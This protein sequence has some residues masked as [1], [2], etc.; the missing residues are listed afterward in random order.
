MAQLSDDCFAF[1][2]ELMTT[3]EALDLLAERLE[4]VVEPEPVALRRALGRILAADVVADRS[5]PPLDNAAVDGY[6]VCFGD[7][8]SGGETRLPVTGR[9]AAGQALDRTP[10]HGE[11]IRIFTGAPMPDGMDTVL[12]QEDCRRDG[13]DVVIPPGIRLGANRRRAGEDIESGSVILRTGRR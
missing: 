12:M 2:G 8:D 3:G 6:A 7:L 4:I 9:V 1:G 10:A 11:A 5:V 13:A